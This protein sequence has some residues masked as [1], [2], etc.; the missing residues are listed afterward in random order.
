MSEDLK[1]AMIKTSSGCN[2]YSLLSKNR[3][4]SLLILYC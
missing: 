3:L 2:T 1:M 4:L